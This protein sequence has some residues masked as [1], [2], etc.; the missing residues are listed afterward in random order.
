M[1]FV[2]LLMLH[3]LVKKNIISSLIYR[4]FFT[5]YLYFF[6]LYEKF[7]AMETLEVYITKVE[8]QLER[9]VKIIKSDRGG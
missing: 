1:T 7:Q 9:K 4:L 2:D 5:L 3:L 8:R 6:L